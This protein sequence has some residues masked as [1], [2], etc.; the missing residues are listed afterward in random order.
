[1][2][3]TSYYKLIDWWLLFCFIVLVLILQFH[4]YLAYLMSKA[5][6]EPKIGKN[7]T[8]VEPF[9]VDKNEDHLASQQS[10][11]FA[12]RLNMA[13]KMIFLIVIILFNLL[14]WTVA[15]IEHFKTTEKMISK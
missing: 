11:I 12:A 10:Y 9:D 15:L 1:M 14:F 6:T 2:P 13:G 4:T 3:A 5:K 8:K 7:V